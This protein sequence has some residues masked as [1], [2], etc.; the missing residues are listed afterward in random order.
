[1][2]KAALGSKGV[3]GIIAGSVILAIAIGAA[4]FFMS[5]RKNNVEEKP[6][7]APVQSVE[8]DGRGI[9]LNDDNAKSVLADYVNK[10]VEEGFFE[11]CMTNEWVFKDGIS[12]PTKVYIKNEK[13]NSKMFFFDVYDEN[14]KMIY[15]SPYLAV[16]SEM[17]QFELA[18]IPEKGIHE[19]KMMYHLVNDDKS[20]IS[21]FA[22]A[23][24]ID[25]R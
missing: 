22:V 8:P 3:K 12:D 5:G 2:E 14:E 15:S 24:T 25:I 20:E 4:V 6:V 11:T 23:V 9:I 13:T 19:G 21:K 7:S 17:P 18:E 16:G 10:Q 1:M